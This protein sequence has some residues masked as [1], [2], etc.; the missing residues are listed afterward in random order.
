MAR[1]GLHAGPQ[2][3]VTAVRHLC[4]GGRGS[5]Q[6]GELERGHTSRSHSFAYT[7]TRILGLCQPIE[8]QIK[9]TLGLESWRVSWVHYQTSCPTNTNASLKGLSGGQRWH[10]GPPSCLCRSAPSPRKQSA[11]SSKTRQQCTDAHQA[12]LSN[13]RESFL[14]AQLL[15]P[16]G[17]IDLS[18][19]SQQLQG[20]SLAG[21]VPR[22]RVQLYS[23]AEKP[24]SCSE[25]LKMPIV[26]CSPRD[27]YPYP[28]S[29]KELHDNF[30]VVGTED[31]VSAEVR[32][33]PSKASG[34]CSLDYPSSQKKKKKKND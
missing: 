19:V 14:P 7:V 16:S 23:S 11:P 15:C 32:A 5:R 33:V 24:C 34:P 12:Q 30:R 13:S 8:G 2:D 27:T 17:P 4:G 10:L 25:G 18:A 26:P 1:G 20:L 21:S 22:A 28:W 3:G 9:A 6:T 31:I 29:G